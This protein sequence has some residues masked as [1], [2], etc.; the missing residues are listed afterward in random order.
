M[1]FLGSWFLMGLLGVAGAAIP[2]ILH[3]FFRSRYRTVPWAAMEF[4]LTS[5]EQTSRRLKFQELLLLLLRCAVLLILALALARP[6][7]QLIAG[8][9]RDSVHAVFVIDNSMS[10]GAREGAKTRFDLARQ[11]AIAAVNQLPPHSTVQIY[12]CSNTASEPLL[13]EPANLDQARTIIEN[14]ELTHLS[15]DLAPGLSA[16]VETLR[17]SQAGNKELYVFSDM[18]KQGFEQNGSEVNSLF[19]EAKRLSTVYLVRCGT[20]K[21]TNATVLGIVPQSKIPRPGQRVGYAVVVKNTGSQPVRQVRVSLAVDGKADEAESQTI[22]E[23]SPGQTYS[24]ALSA[25]FD[26]PGLRVLTA[27][28]SND[29]L[30]GDN[31]FDQVVEVRNQVNILLIDGNLNQRDPERSASFYLVNALTPVRDVD[32]AK[33]HLQLDVVSPSQAGG[34]ALEGKAICIL[35]NVPLFFGLGDEPARQTKEFLD[36]LARFV[37]KGHGLLIYSGDNVVPDVYNRSLGNR[38]LLPVPLTEVES[39]PLNKPLS[40][41]RKSANV[42]AFR[43]F[44]E[45][46]YYQALSDWP[47]YKSVGQLEPDSVKGEERDGDPARVA[48]RYTNGKPAVVTRKVG[49]GEVMF[50]GTSADPGWK[51]RSLEATWN[52]LQRWPGF[53]PLCEAEVNHLLAGQAQSH[54]GTVGDPLRYLPQG[55]DDKLTYVLI[56]PGERKDGN[57]HLLTEGKRVPL[58]P[59]VKTKDRSQVV[60]SG[61]SK[62]GV[63]YLTTRERETTDRQ[64]FAMVPDARESLD[65]STLEDAEIDRQIGFAPVHLTVQE[66]EELVFGAARTSREWTTWLLWAVLALAFGESLLAWKCGRAW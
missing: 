45:D 36:A 52:I 62:A 6:A 42:P 26:K 63:Y 3:L 41:D 16:G 53:V 37:R 49:A 30:P 40:I 44:A 57:V 38:G 55:E 43:R 15:T 21:L 58:G 19:T 23:L 64:P 12:T 24:V 14:L 32:K 25:R 5:I 34:A 33:Y 59:P 17:T 29:D 61:L 18:Q 28:L 51:A 46:E 31:W 1:P 48:F 65:L 22:T 4:L 39:F 20:R 10:M 54:N 2:I 11:A 13:R 47:I 27:F 60:A 7:L 56:E 35:V 8:G 50:I 66:S 9:G